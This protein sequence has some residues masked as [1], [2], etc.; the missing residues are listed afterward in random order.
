[1]HE[2]FF[3]LGCEYS[4]FSKSEETHWHTLVIISYE[5]SSNSKEK[6]EEKQDSFDHITDHKPDDLEAEVKLAE[7]P[8]TSEDGEG[9]QH[10][11]VHGKFLGHYFLWRTD[12]WLRSW[13]RA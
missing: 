11:L 3:Y 4:W 10:D 5:A 2:A 13:I 9:F 8:Q 1:M 12:A 6:I 7:A